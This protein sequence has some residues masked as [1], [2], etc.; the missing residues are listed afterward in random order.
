MFNNHELCPAQVAD[1][2]PRYRCLNDEMIKDLRFLVEC[3]VAS[4]IQFEILK[5]KY[6][7]H[8]FHK[9]DIYNTIYKLCKN[10]KEESLD[11]RRLLDAL[12]EKMT[13]DPR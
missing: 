2:I 8:V 6:P 1:L 12:L 4:I 11:S 7:D 10:N 13:I 9:Q 5:K 3:K